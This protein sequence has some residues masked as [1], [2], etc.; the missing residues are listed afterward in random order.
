MGIYETRHG[1]LAL[2][3]QNRSRVILLAHL[4]RRAHGLDSALIDGDAG[5]F[6]DARIRQDS[7]TIFY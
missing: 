4:G 5:I 2:P 7:L 3:I 1:Q 6:H